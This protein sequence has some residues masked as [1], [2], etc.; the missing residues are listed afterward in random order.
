MK[1]YNTGPF[2]KN[3][4]SIFND[5]EKQIKCNKTIKAYINEKL[6][7]LNKTQ[8]KNSPTKIKKSKNPIIIKSIIPCSINSS[9]STNLSDK[10]KELN[11]E[12]E[13]NEN[14]KE[15]IKTSK[16][17]INNLE[18]ILN[19]ILKESFPLSKEE[20]P[21]PT[22]AIKRYSIPKK[23]K[24]ERITSYSREKDG[25][26]KYIK[27]IQSPEQINKYEKYFDV[28]KNY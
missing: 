25:E 16:N 7:N 21:K 20:C 9:T 1:R 17:N 15:Q 8:L 14:L 5:K 11:L 2:D 23:G 26:E 12:I 28:K 4:K 6:K 19:H 24:H 3:K 27:Y 13:E 10:S 22:P 18:E